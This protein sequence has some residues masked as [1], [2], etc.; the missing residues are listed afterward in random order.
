MLKGEKSIPFDCCSSQILHSVFHPD[1]MTNSTESPIDGHPV[2]LV[3]QSSP[4]EWGDQRKPETTGDGC[5]V[6]RT[7]PPFDDQRGGNEACRCWVR[8]SCPSWKKQ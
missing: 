5:Y 6:A 7:R 4:P 2:V 1:C 8:G 3:W